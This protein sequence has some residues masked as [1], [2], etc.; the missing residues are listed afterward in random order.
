ANPAMPK[1]AVRGVYSK[2]ML[3][4]VPDIMREIGYKHA[5]V[6]YGE[7]GEGCMDEAST[8]GTTWVA[9]L[10]ENGD[11]KRYT[12]TPGEFGIEAGNPEE[13]APFGDIKETAKELVR[14]L[15]G[16]STPTRQNIVCLNAALVLCV[17]GKA[18]N[19]QAGYIKSHELI[20][21]GQAYKALEKWVSVQNR[22]PEA[23]LAKLAALSAEL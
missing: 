13:L 18:E 10:M 7:A 12:L 20:E 11:V 9:E 23:G 6:V 1:Y 22:N 19:V 5:F 14:I 16:T 15:K 4:F 17:S 21:N 3:D 8:I 2:E